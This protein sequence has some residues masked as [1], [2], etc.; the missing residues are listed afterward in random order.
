MNSPITH[1]N[2]DELRARFTAFLVTLIK[3]ARINFLK[4]YQR[5]L[6]EVSLSSIPEE[7]LAAEI[8]LHHKQET[9]F[10]FEEG[11]LAYAFAKLPLMKREILTML[12]VHQM[13]PTEIADKLNCSVGHVYNQRS[14]ALR[15]LRVALSGND[16]ND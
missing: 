3:R 15:R 8:E 2:C 6:C 4:K 10:D 14:Q 12:F 16:Y 9:D 11:R 13:K 1:N 5:P 7:L